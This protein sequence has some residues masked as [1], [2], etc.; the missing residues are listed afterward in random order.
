MADTFFN[1][2]IDFNSDLFQSLD[3]SFKLFLH[4]L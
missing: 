4:R 3:G 1:S 2:C